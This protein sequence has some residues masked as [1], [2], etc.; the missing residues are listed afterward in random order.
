MTREEI[1]DWVDSHIGNCINE[2]LPQVQGIYSF[3]VHSCGEGRVLSSEPELITEGRTVST[4]YVQDI[5][6]HVYMKSPTHLDA[7]VFEAYCSE[8][9]VL[10]KWHSWNRERGMF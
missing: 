5:V 6:D 3:G 8:V 1:A 10:A 2:E 4:I 9:P 7:T